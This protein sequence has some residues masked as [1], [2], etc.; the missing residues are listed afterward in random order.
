MM[1]ADKT[2]LIGSVIHRLITPSSLVARVSGIEVR[3]SQDVVTLA[4][5]NLGSGGWIVQAKATVED[6]GGVFDPEHPVTEGVRANLVLVAS[7]WAASSGAVASDVAIV[8]TNWRHATIMA[9]I[10]FSSSGS[11]LVELK[12]SCRGGAV[13]QK[14]KFS[15]IVLTAIKQDELITLEM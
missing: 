12:A 4:A 5:V 2:T 3:Q 6:L 8:D 10:G 14:A 1:P 13:N 11:T 7:P 15:D 9:I